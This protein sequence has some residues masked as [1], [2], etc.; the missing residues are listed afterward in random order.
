MRNSIEIT[1]TIYDWNGTFDELVNEFSA[2]EY[3]ILLEEG[4]LEYT[5]AEWF[6]EECYNTGDYAD[7]L[8]NFIGDWL[9]SSISNG[10]KGKETDNLF[11]LW[12]KR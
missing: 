8:Y 10:A 7:M 1:D 11:R 12:N 5:D 9:M 3:K 2:E 4:S 6:E